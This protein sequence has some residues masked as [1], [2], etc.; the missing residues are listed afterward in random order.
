M[1]LHLLLGKLLLEDSGKEA[2]QI[3]IRSAIVCIPMFLGVVAAYHCCIFLNKNA[4]SAA[5]IMI[6]I[7]TVVPMGMKV[8]GYKLSGVK[9]VSDMLMYNLMQVEYVETAEGY[10]RKF[11]W[12]TTAGIVKCII[13]GIC[14]ILIFSL[15]GTKYFQKKEIR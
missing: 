9:K 13:A 10:L 1:G 11:S 12:D 3:F 5:A 4:I 6:I 2:T 8:L 15:I 14:A 7:L